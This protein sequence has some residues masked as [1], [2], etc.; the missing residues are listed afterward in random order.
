MQLDYEA[1][2]IEK[3]QW[4][5]NKPKTNSPVVRCDEDKKPNAINRKLV[6]ECFNAECRYSAS[7]HTFRMILKII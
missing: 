4:R 7:W 6:S 2:N 1:T 5:K 3:V